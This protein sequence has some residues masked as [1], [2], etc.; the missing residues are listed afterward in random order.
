MRMYTYGFIGKITVLY[1]EYTYKV[2]AL[3]IKVTFLDLQT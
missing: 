2:I 1:V 3:L